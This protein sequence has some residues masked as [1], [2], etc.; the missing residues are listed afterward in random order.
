MTMAA[1]GGL[2]VPAVAAA[3]TSLASPA[4]ADTGCLW[5][6]TSYPQGTKVDS[7]GVTFQCDISGS[8]NGPSPS[9]VPTGETGVGTSVPGV[10]DGTQNPADYSPGATLE[11]SSGEAWSLGSVWDD[12]GSWASFRRSVLPGGGGAPPRCPPGYRPNQDGGCNPSPI[13]IDVDGSGFHLTSASHGVWFDFYGTHHPVKLAWI[14]PGSTNAFLVLPVHGK[15]SNGRELFGNLTP[16]PPSAHPNGF[17]ALATYATLTSGGHRSNIIDSDD[18]IYSRLRLWQFSNQGG[19]LAAGKLST[20]PRLGIK[21]IFLNYRTT[22]ITDRYGNAFRYQARVISANPHAGKYTY[23]VFL[24]AA[25]AATARPATA[26]SRPGTGNDGL[27]GLL[28]L[29][30]LGLLAGWRWSRPRARRPAEPA[31]PGA[32]D[33]TA[34]PDNQTH[35]LLPVP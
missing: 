19:R 7:N 29:L 14:A 15:V 4:L 28:G 35:Q 6:G 21:A 2:A 5:A 32:G 20:L 34:D 1:L 13:I 3:V 12:I 10:Y 17:L 18:P 27:L 31:S 23:D 11:D 30:P 16:Q 25:G 22:S 33:M 26:A 8:T 24:Q 9:W